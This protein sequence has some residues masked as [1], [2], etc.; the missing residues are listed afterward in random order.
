MEITSR[1]WR[2]V[3]PLLCLTDKDE[4]TNLYISH[5]LTYDV[6]ETGR[7]SDE[8]WENLKAAVKQYIEYCYSGHLEGL[9]QSAS[10]EEWKRYFDV[11]RTSKRVTRV[12]EIELELKPNFPEKDY[13]VWLQGVDSDA[14]NSPQVQ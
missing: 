3:G 4:E 5:C 14:R 2:K 11:L 8:S 7:T 13:P 9:L 10:S 1:D 12:D 6:M